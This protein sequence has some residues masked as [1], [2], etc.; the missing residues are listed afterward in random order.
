ME[1]EYTFVVPVIT[2]AS[3]SPNPVDTGA[4][5][6]VSVGVEEQQKTLYSEARKCGEF[7]VGEI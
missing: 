7:L 3:F 4:A 1:T 5:T 2:S 6:L